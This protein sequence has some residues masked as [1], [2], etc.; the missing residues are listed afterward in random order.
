[1]GNGYGCNVGRIA[2]MDFT[3]GSLMTDEGKLKVYLGQGKITGDPIPENF[4]GCG[5]VAEIA[6]LQDVLLHI[7]VKGH[8]HHV[9]ITPGWVQ[10]SLRE[11]LGHYLGLK[12]ELP[13]EA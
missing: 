2:P 5:G 11:A 8:R 13:Q 6:H 7:G 12:V 9:S 3:F 1:V 4:F 10:T